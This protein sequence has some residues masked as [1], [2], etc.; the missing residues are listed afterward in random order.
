LWQDHRKPHQRWQL[1]RVAEES[2]EVFYTIGHPNSPMVMEAPGPW[3]PGDPVVMRNYDQNGDK[4]HRQ[5]KMVPVPGPTDD[6]YM[7]INRLSGLVIDVEHGDAEKGAIKQ[8]T[9]WKAPDDRQHWKLIPTRDTVRRTSTLVAWG[10]NAAGEPGRGTRVDTSVPA[11]VVGLENIHLTSIDAGGNLGSTAL[12]D[13]TFSLAADSEKRVWAWGLNAY[14]QLG[15]DPDKLPKLL[16]STE[17]RQVPGL[18][19][20]KVTAVAAGGGH[21]LALDDNKHVWAWGWNNYCQ[22]G[23]TSSRNRAAAAQVPNLEDKGVRFT[24]ISA[25]GG[26][27][28]ALDEDGVVWTWGWNNVYQLGHT[29]LTDWTTWATAAPVPSLKSVHDN[30]KVRFTAIA[31]G[32]GGGFK[33]SVH[34]MR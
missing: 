19:K 28:L 11:P 26:H 18:Q 1:T 8:Y 31:A 12:F 4:R 7:I 21:S 16:Y 3:K 24:A 5:W 33:G 27:S 25:G 15:E 14:G 29:N 22:L 13:G 17:P 10:W 34:H 23:D 9:S 32:G 6:V 20:V 2:G 30:D